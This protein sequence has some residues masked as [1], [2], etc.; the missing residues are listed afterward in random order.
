[1]ATRDEKGRFVKGHPGGPGRP[2]REVE[3]EFFDATVAVVSPEDWSAIVKKAV[4]QAKEGNGYAR[5]WLS[6]YLMGKPTQRTELTGADGGPIE[7]N[8][9]LSG[10]TNEQLSTLANNLKD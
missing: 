8:V 6:D 10:L 9:D 4:E 2:K 5:S 3:Q 1:M 7:S